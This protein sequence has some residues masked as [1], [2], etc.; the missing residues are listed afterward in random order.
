MGEEITKPEAILFDLGSTLLKDRMSGG[1]N[2]R[3]RA[4]LDAEAF[5]PFV[6]QGFDLPRALADAMDQMY[7]AGLE[8]FHVKAWLSE[9]LLGELSDP[10][11]SPEALEKDIRSSIIHYSPPEDS[12]RV[13]RELMRMEIPMAVVSNTIF[14]AELL[15]HDLKEHSVLEAFQFVLSSAEFGMRKPHPSIF[16]NAVRQ[17]GSQPASTW[18]VGDLWL[19]DVMGS[20]DAGLVPVWLNANAETPVNPVPHN[21]V[22]NWTEL[23]GLLGV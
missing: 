15:R 10:A 16:L 11:G 19:N 17:I 22:R 3:V 5:A 8:E 20:T 1:L 12:V 7:K 13:L 21:R 2:D 6:K 9:N 4:H 14:S 18:Y 23:G